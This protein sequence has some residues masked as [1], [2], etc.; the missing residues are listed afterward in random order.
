MTI[1]D[2][3]LISDEAIRNDYRH[4]ENRA[5]EISFSVSKGYGEARKPVAFRYINENEFN[6]FASMEQD[7]YWVEL[8][9]AVPLLVM[10][11]FY[12]MFA[13]H[14]ILP[15]LDS[16]GT[17]A[18]DFELPFIVDPENFDRR[19]NWHIKTNAVRAFAAGTIADLCSTFVIL[20]EFGHVICGHLEGLNHFDRGD[21]LAEFVSRSSAP[22]ANILKARQRSK[23]RQAWE[24]EAD[25]IAA[26]L[27]TQFVD[28]LTKHAADNER[29]GRVFTE[30]DGFHRE[31]TLAI[32][33][34]ALFAMFCYMQGARRQLGADSNHPH[35]Q[36]RS[37]Y[38]KDIILLEMEN[39]HALNVEKFHELLDE[40]LDET[41][42]VLDELK[43]FD[44]RLNSE[45]YSRQIERERKKLVK[46]QQEYRESCTQWRWFEW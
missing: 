42:I 34:S 39:R 38:V 4:L 32:A 20:H 21:R 5:K 36:V 7:R 16:S 45:S 26:M 46:L 27:L 12:R 43:L 37:R 10:M 33:V 19:V 14:R 41:M 1:F 22:K 6:A 11:L 40:R 18:S 17:P 30:K 24:S 28:D 3:N 13:D 2:Y 31:H 15:H 44:P 9:A 35:P 25:M 8:N 23:R 29:L